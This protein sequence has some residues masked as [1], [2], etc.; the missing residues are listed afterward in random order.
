MSLGLFSGSLADFLSLART[1]AEVRCGYTRVRFTVSEQ[2]FNVLLWSNRH[3]P[4]DSPAHTHTHTLSVAV[5]AF[6]PE[7]SNCTEESNS[8][9]LSHTSVTVCPCSS[10]VRSEMDL[11]ACGRPCVAFGVRPG[12]ALSSGALMGHVDDSLHHWRWEVFTSSF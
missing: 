11:N 2:F 9:N 8:F 1:Q 10:H 3:T 5:C 12:S 7:F 6:T 4:S